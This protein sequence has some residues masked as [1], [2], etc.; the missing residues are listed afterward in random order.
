MRGKRETWEGGGRF[1]EFLFTN[2]PY[3]VGHIMASPRERGERNREKRKVEE[4][5]VREN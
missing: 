1:C 3:I 5:K 2:M 4:R